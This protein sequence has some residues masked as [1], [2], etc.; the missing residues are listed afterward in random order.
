MYKLVS[1]V[2]SSSE[3][4]LGKVLI[5]FARVPSVSFLLVF[6]MKNF[7]HSYRRCCRR[8]EEFAAGK[9]MLNSKAYK[10]AKRF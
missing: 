9:R 4:V 5:A 8:N 1:T 2:M 10:E 7:R 6:L 3:L